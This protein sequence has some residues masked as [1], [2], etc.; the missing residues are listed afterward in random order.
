MDGLVQL[1]AGVT[2]AGKLNSR[3]GYIFPRTFW[4]R[5]RGGGIGSADVL[6]EPLGENRLD[7]LWLAD[8]RVEKSF[9]IGRTRLSGMV[10]VFNLF[11]SA[12]V[13]AREYRQNL[14]TAN[15]ID[16]ILSARVIRFGVRWM[17]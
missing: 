6:L 7:N 14:D 8:L 5:S 1:P 13:L 10:D 17:F 12:T 16:D 15:R 9:D 3:Q 2:L 11:N 4:T